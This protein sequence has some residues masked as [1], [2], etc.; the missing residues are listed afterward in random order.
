MLTE[1]ASVIE[2]GGTA[3]RSS[4]RSTKLPLVVR[5]S[6]YVKRPHQHVRFTKQA[7]FIR[8]HYTC[9]YCGEQSKDLTL[10]H[11]IPKMRGGGTTWTNVVTACKSCNSA[12]G[13]K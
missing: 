1:K 6:Y 13:D 12:K 10:D 3:V 7:V 4:R 9:Q 11:V 8:D 2:S 5:L